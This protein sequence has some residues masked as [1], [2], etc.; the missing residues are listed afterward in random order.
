MYPFLI[1]EFGKQLNLI[2]RLFVPIKDEPDSNIHDCPEARDKMP[3]MSIESGKFLAT[4]AVSSGPNTAFSVVFLHVEL[5]KWRFFSS[6][7]YAMP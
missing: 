4:N 2:I 3:C 1:D 5:P 6:N 7:A